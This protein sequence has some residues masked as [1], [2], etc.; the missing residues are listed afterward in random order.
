MNSESSPGFF[1]VT[2][3]E[4]EEDCLGPLENI[5]KGKLCDEV[6]KRTDRGTMPNPIRSLGGH[7]HLFA[8][9]PPGQKSRETKKFPKYFS[10]QCKG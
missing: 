4:L 6:H 9:F 2:I 3:Q 5:A 7:R 8:R 10:L 1:L